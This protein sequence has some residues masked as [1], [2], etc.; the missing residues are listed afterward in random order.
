MKL[1][2][3]FLSILLGIV[4]MPVNAVTYYVS[5]TGF[6][7]NN[8]TSLSTPVKTIIKGLSKAQQSGDTIYVLT[9]TYNEAIWIGRS[10]ITLSAYPD[11][12]P[13]IDGGATLPNVD[14]G[15][16]LGIGG[17]Y[18]TVSGFEVKN[19]NI[20]GAHTGGIG[21]YVQGSH[22]TV[23][24]MQVHDTWENGIIVHGD[25]VIVEYSVVY[26]SVMNNYQGRQAPMWASGLSAGRNPGASAL[27]PGIVSYAILR[28]NIVYNNWGEGMSCYECDHCIME[29][30]IVYDNWTVNMYLS[31]AT[32][33]LVQRNMIYI[34]SV[35]IISMRNN[36]GIALADEVAGV[37]RSV[38]NT[39]INNFIYNAEFQAFSW[40][41]V[42]NSG[43]NNVLIANN[44]VV[45]GKLSTGSGGSSVISNA[46]SQIR[47][48]IIYGTGY[49][50]SNS[51]IIFSNNLWS[52]TPPSAAASATNI[53]GNPLLARTGATGPAQLTAGYFKLLSTSPAI[54]KAAELSVVKEDYFKTLRG[55][56]PDIGGYEHPSPPF[57]TVTVPNS[58]EKWPVTSR[59]SITWNATDNTS[60]TSISLYFRTPSISWTKIDSFPASNGNGSYLWTV[61]SQPLAVAW[62]QVNAYDAGGSKG[63]DTSDS[64]FSIV[65][66]PAF[67]SLDSVSLLKGGNLNYT[68]TANNPL[69]SASV[70][71]ALT[72]NSS[73]ITMVGN[74]I[75]GTAPSEA[76]VDT[77]K[78]SLSVGGVEYDTL[79][80]RVYIKASPSILPLVNISKTF[81][82]KMQNHKIIAAIDRIG[83]LKIKAYD[84]CGAQVMN[85]NIGV[86]AG[87]YYIPFNFKTGVYLI[88]L[89][90]EGR[91]LLNKFLVIRQAH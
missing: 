72:V 37:P 45:D 89:E 84:V 31:D 71:T 17:D 85:F 75:S 63:S 9:G 66:T 83:I 15:V 79:K 4:I 35:P 61:P 46:N 91:V 32:N 70:F 33:S 87:N 22:N 82:L 7:T 30:N 56:E 52:Q 55:S 58:G 16:L 80:L 77:F 20:T 69:D 28:H 26:Q 88:K 50:P 49:V 21:V 38:N 25:Y 76:R 57:T 14:N 10:G 43:L 6:E 73:W 74:N 48:N 23:S 65:N 34:S 3:S 47:N 86:D 67:T 51:G 53:I 81:S 5:A 40:T 29:D 54:N 90:H 41:I 44:T 27:I 42:P 12:T 8:G 68:I 2:I 64:P 11:N 13:V 60:V 59:R 24:R 36:I 78:V 19:S 18:N 1:F 39:V 62:I